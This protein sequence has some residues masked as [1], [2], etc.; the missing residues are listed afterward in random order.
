MRK[1]VPPLMVDTEVWV[2]TD[3]LYKEWIDKKLVLD[4]G[5]IAEYGR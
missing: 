3:F 4:A 5:E 2:P 1:N